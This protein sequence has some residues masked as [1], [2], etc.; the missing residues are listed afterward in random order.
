[1]YTIKQ[2]AARTGLT[3]P[4]LRAWERRYGIVTPARTP[5]GYRVYDDEAIARISAMRRLVD[6]GWAPSTAAAAIV[7][8]TAPAP[9]EALPVPGGPAQ[10]DLAL[11]EAFV[12]A[13][14]AL[15]AGGIEGILDEMFALRSFERVASDY[16]LPAVVAV[17]DAWQAGRIDVAA[18]HLAS[19]AVLRRLAAAYQAA[20]RP[21]IDSGAVIVGLPPGSRH[22]LGALA[23]AIAAR[24]AGMPV[25]YLGPDLPIDDWVAAAG[26]VRARAA[27]VGVV[28]AGDRG[29]ARRVAEALRSAR[30]G[31]VVAF[32]GRHAAGGAGSPAFAAESDEGTTTPLTLPDDVGEAVATLERALAEASPG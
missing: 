14:G 24:R 5:S 25:V 12:A 21:D 30:P 20:G 3:V 31:I 26:R 23:F 4:V 10:G 15:D 32:G 22:A 16:L 17:G 27:V 13:A 18:E 28:T 8:G 11:R 7:A 2:A 19:Q 6:A 9:T 29:P 1:M